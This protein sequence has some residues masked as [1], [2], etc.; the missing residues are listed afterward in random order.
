MYGPGQTVW[1]F[2]PAFRKLRLWST[3]SR[4]IGETLKTQKS[5]GLLSP[6]ESRL[7]CLMW[8][9]NCQGNRDCWI[10]GPLTITVDGG[11][12]LAKNEEAKQYCKAPCPLLPSGAVLPFPALHVWVLGGLYQN[13]G[14]CWSTAVQ[15]RWVELQPS[16]RFSA[17]NCRL[18]RSYFCGAGSPESTTHG[19]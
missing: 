6:V 12:T 3:I 8:I 17:G 14:G 4:Q 2:F 19:Q 5:S 16:N 13:G 10:D 15:C 7:A 9:T 18:Y 1:R 11:A